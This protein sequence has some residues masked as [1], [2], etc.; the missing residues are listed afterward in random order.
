VLSR[1]KQLLQLIPECWFTAVARLFPLGT[2]FSVL[3]C[4]RQIKPL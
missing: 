2:A 1:P 3:T 4:S